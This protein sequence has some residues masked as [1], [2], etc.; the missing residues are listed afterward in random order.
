MPRR[1]IGATL[2]N[3]I[4]SP[5]CHAVNILWLTQNGGFLDFRT[6]SKDSISYLKASFL[7]RCNETQ[8]LSCDERKPS[9]N[10]LLFIEYNS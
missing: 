8:Q 1:I 3:A 10:F 7:S 2:C 9:T 4:P 6:D 5:C